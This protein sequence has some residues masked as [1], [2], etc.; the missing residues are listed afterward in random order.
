MYTPI[1]NR[2]SDRAKI[3]EFMREYPFATLVTAR[4]GKITATHLPVLIDEQDSQQTL[5]VPPVGESDIGATVSPP[6]DLVITAHLARGNTQWMDFAS[7]DA[8]GADALVIFQEPHAF[9]STRHYEKP[10]SVP[11]WNYIAV[12]AYGIPKILDSISE[13]HRVVERMVMQFEASMEQFDSLPDDFKH[14]KL[15]GIAAFELRVTRLEARFKLSQ[16]RTRVEQENII[17]ALSA[18]PENIEFEI[19]A[20]M[21]ETLGGKP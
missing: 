8:A 9:I 14:T 3:V 10:L 13:R 20:R 12:H 6:P 17:E 11:T 21:R 18:R 1:H 16:D 15:N 4:G 19:A 7:G 5:P 2:E